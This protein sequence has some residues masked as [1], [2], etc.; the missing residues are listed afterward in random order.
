[1]YL[2]FDVDDGVNLN[3]ILK[4]FNESLVKKQ[5]KSADSKIQYL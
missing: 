3:K 4:N 2:D 1:M 5:L